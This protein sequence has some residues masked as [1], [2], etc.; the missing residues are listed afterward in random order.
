HDEQGNDPAF[1]RT[2]VLSFLTPSGYNP[3]R[4]VESPH[5]RGSTQRG[6]PRHLRRRTQMASRLEEQIL[7]RKWFYHFKLPGGA[8]TETYLPEDVTPIHTTREQMLFQVL[9]P[10]FHGRWHTVT[11]VDLACHQGYFSQKLAEKGCRH[12]LGLDARPQHIEDAELIRA[13]YGRENLTFRVGS[14]TEL[15][16][17]R[18]GTFD[19][20]LM[21]G[22]LY[23]LENPLGAVKL[24]R[25]L[26]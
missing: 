21:F 11:C 16:P 19:V 13:A 8:V 23:H 3:R 12:V 15:D 6:P 25:A 7:G 2:L 10:I 26:T 4:T 20:V 17:A 9:D 24:A 22:L 1:P 14:V 5:G 18:L